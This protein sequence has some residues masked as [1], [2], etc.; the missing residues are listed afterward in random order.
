MK[1]KNNK[2]KTIN[3]NID[4]NFILDAYKPY[5][6]KMPALI[7]V[8]YGGTGS[9]KS[10]FIATHVVIT[11]LITKNLKWLVL[12]KERSQMTKTVIKQLTDIIKKM[13]LWD[14]VKYNKTDGEIVFPNGSVIMFSGYDDPEK[15][16]GVKADRVW[17][18]E[19]TDFGDEDLDHMWGRLRGSDLKNPYIIVS[20]NP[21][22]INHWVRKKLFNDDFKALNDDIFILK[23][24]Y[25]DN[26][27]YGD[28]S[29]FDRLKITNPRL[30]RVNALGEFGV[31][32]E[33]IF[34]NYTK[35][36]LP[37]DDH[38]YDRISYGLDF[39]F[40]HNTAIV[41]TGYRKGHGTSP[42]RLFIIDEIYIG[43]T[44]PLDIVR[45]IKEKWPTNYNKIKII[46]DNSRPESIEL[47]NQEG[48]YVVPCKKYAG[49]VLDEIEWIQ[50]REIIID[51]RCKGVL[52]EITGYQWEKTKGG[53]ITPKPVKIDDD[54]IDAFRYSTQ[55]FRQPEAFIS[56]N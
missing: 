22:D 10:F 12:R 25:R 48:L 23:T 49:S 29:Y 11:C 18:E 5:A 6:Y 8:F 36:E 13:G 54:A 24:T 3:I 26:P 55:E 45:K 2:K 37:Q 1:M 19:L 30:Y 17:M 42:D 43:K 41:K 7:N 50:E 15:I 47:M 9:G 44:T 40:S 46:A 34:E 35:E 32:G 52:G 28:T 53:V 21:I 38:L 4:P 56:F 16:K 14:Y 27:H 20:F 39:G 31:L 51:P 33:L